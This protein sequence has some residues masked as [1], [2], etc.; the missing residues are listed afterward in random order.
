M[1]TKKPSLLKPILIC[2]CNFNFLGIGYLLIGQ[3]KRWMIAFGG[4][5]AVLLVAHFTNASKNPWLWAVIFLAI[6]I[7]MAVDLW[8]L[9]KKDPG[10]CDK[11]LKN[12]LTFLIL[13]AVLLVVLFGGGFYFYRWM[14]EDLYWQGVLAYQNDDMRTAFKDLYSVSYLYRLSLNPTVLEA[15]ALMGEVSLIVDS[16]NRVEAGDFI[17][18]SEIVAKFE[19]LYPDSPKMEKIKNIGIDAYIG[20]AKQLTA[21][22]EF[23]ASLEKITSVMTVLPVQAE[24]RKTEIDEVLAANYL[25]W[26]QDLYEKQELA[27]S[28]QKLEIVTTEYVG[29]ESFTDAFTGASLARYD[30]ALQLEGEEEYDL[31]WEQ[32]QTI[33]EKYSTAAEYEDA[34]THAANMLL[35]WG[36]SLANQDHFLLA[37]EKFELVGTYS[38]SSLLL[39]DVEE[40]K[41]TTI[42]LLANDTGEDGQVALA[43]AKTAACVGETITDPSIGILEEEPKKAMECYNYGLTIP[44]ELIA[45]KPGNLAYVVDRIDDSRRVQSC[46]YVTSYD[47]RTLERWQYYSEIIVKEVLTGKTVYDK[48]FYGSSPESCPYEY[49]FGSMTEYLYG[50]DVDDQKITDW[51]GEVLQ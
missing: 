32:F 17:T 28:I 38:S 13:A 47:R 23:E 12:N 14:G 6:L 35:D 37:L 10:V 50:D 2:L 20:A 7:G 29:S 21:S 34:K 4:T 16:Q 42:L 51:L 39:A 5:L 25:A 19:K 26:G 22:G 24:D 44:D 45:D 9:L 27:N 46:D 8:L 33:F 15:Q 31:A 3:K 1:E 48:T 18:A 49:Y 30:Y 40:E 43:S 11:V 36:K 41:Q